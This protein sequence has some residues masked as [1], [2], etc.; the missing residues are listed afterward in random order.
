MRQAVPRSVVV[1]V[2]LHL[3]AAVVFGGLAHLDSTNQFPDMVVNDDANFAVGLYA[4]RNL[5]IGAA[6]AAAL[7]LLSRMALLG[8]MAARFFTDIADLIAATTRIES[9][10]ALVGQLVFFGLLFWSE[11]YVLRTLFRLE[12]EQH[13]HEVAQ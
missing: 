7:V 3:L 10:G 2:V 1:I 9:A 5:G 11:I 8:L 12:S 6:L 4:N 13:N